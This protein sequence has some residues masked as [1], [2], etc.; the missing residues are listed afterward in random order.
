MTS[1]WDASLGNIT[2]L[3]KARGMWNNSE[4]LSAQNLSLSLRP[5]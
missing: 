4:S 3:I 2:D 5:H 1:Y